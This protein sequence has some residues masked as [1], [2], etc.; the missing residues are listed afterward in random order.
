[1]KGY[2][3]LFRQKG[4]QFIKIGMTQTESVKDRYT[5]FCMYAP[6]G[7]EIVHII[8]TEN[9]IKLE[10]ELHIMFKK[11]RLNG[12]FFLLNDED[13][14]NVKNLENYR[15][16]LLSDFFWNYVINNKN[17]SMENLQKVIKFKEK[18]ISIDSHNILNKINEKFN[19]L[20]VTN[21]EILSYINS[22]G[23][24]ITSKHLG[25]ILSLKYKSKSKYIEGKT[26]RIYTIK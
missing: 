4:T 20:D 2:V 6:N 22:L 16:K 19:G 15:I 17:L 8:E 1:M 26:Q 18:H 24:N 25:Q 12:E 9:A 14:E 11:K 7:G 13:I 5:S 21:T 23:N 10:K 3:Y